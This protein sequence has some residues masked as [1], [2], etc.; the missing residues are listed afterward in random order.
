MSAEKEESFLFVAMA[1]NDGCTHTH[2]RM[3]STNL[4]Q[5][6]IEKKKN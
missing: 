3:K 2:A 4:A 5:S 1:M 6:G